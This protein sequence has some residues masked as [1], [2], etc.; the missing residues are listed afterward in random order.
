MVEDTVWE[1]LLKGEVHHSREA[2]RRRHS[3]DLLHELTRRGDHVAIAG[4]P[5]EV[6]AHSHLREEGFPKWN[7]CGKYGR[8]SNVGMVIKI[9]EACGWE[10]NKF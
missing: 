10:R 2:S 8:N 5:D 4:L 6:Q 1:H 9:H 3:Q 7:A